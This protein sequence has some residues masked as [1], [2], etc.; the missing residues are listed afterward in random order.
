MRITS[1]NWVSGY[2]VAYRINFSDGA[3]EDRKDAL[4]A[5]CL[6]SPLQSTI[7]HSQGSSLPGFFTAKAYL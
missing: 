1:A 3:V 4:L 5:V 7:R 6:F 2:L